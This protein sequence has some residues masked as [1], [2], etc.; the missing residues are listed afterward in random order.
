MDRMRLGIRATSLTR[1][2]LKRR[3]T[4]KNPC[5]IDL[6]DPVEPS[7]SVQTD[8]SFVAEHSFRCPADTPRLSRH[9]NDRSFPR[10]VRS[11]QY[12]QSRVSPLRYQSFQ[13]RFGR[14]PELM[15]KVRDPRTRN[16]WTFL[17]TL[18]SSTQALLYTDA[19]EAVDAFTKAVNGEPCRRRERRR[20][21]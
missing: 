5:W 12:L 16:I 7:G 14:F 19:I 9:W 11:M 4:A 17:S 1:E 21:F 2:Q 10:A 3:K 15:W 20:C 18:R 8:T 6:I 13:N